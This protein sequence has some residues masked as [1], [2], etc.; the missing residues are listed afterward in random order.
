[1]NQ[2]TQMNI[3]LTI[4]AKGIANRINNEIANLFN[5]TDFVSTE[6]KGNIISIKFIKDK[7]TYE[8]DLEKDYPF[9]P[10]V[11]IKYNGNSYKKSLLNYS[12]KVQKILKRD[13]FMECLCCNTLLCGANWMPSC[14]ICH[15]INEM[16]KIIKIQKEIIIKILCDEIRFRYLCYFAEF[17]KYLF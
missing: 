4:K 8:L 13:Y 12:E 7:K 17:E 2:S 9:K 1:M 3:D 16:D 15:I 6:R 11:N 10:P 5:Q 14:N